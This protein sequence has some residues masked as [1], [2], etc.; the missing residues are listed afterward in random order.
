[1]MRD[2][3]HREEAARRNQNQRNQQWRPRANFTNGDEE[4]ENEM[5]N[6]NMDEQM[7]EVIEEE[8]VIENEEFVGEEDF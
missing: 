4:L 7:E 2:C 5:D 6:L 8:E 3:P 1:M